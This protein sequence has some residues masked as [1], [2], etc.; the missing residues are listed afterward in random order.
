[1]KKSNKYIKTLLLIGLL[2][3]SFVNANKFDPSSVQCALN[4]KDYGE[5][6]IGS[7][8]DYEWKKGLSQISKSTGYF[9]TKKITSKG[10]NSCQV[11][12]KQHQC[13]TM[14]LDKNWEKKFGTSNPEFSCVNLRTG[15]LVPTGEIVYKN[16]VQERMI[17][18]RCPNKNGISDCSNE[19][20]SKR[21]TD[22]KKDV[23]DKNN[24]EMESVC[25]GYIRTPRYFKAGKVGDKALCALTNPQ[26]KALYKVIIPM[27]YRYNAPLKKING[28]TVSFKPKEIKID[29]KNPSSMDSIFMNNKKLMS[30]TG[31]KPELVAIATRCSSRLFTTLEKSGGAQ[32][33]INQNKKLVISRISAWSDKMGLVIPGKGT[34]EERLEVLT[35]YHSN[36]YGNAT[37]PTGLESDV[38]S[39]VPIY[40]QTG[41]Y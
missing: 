41:L 12:L 8:G 13:L 28:K 40:Q 14:F 26:G 10:K 37:G 2:C 3:T 15:E 11:E 20:N 39:C 4:S 34:T 7:K 21:G 35:K 18:M 16:K 33:L 36:K 27:E 32:D 19:S 9:D 25:A 24:W 31:T 29:S 1:M 30:M 22:F 38:K 23:L 17:K 6:Y 5:M